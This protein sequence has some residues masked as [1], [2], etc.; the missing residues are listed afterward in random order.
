MKQLI[1]TDPGIKMSFKLVNILI[2]RRN[3]IG[4]KYVGIPI[5]IYQSV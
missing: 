1:F 3:E 4:K 5:Y 2:Y